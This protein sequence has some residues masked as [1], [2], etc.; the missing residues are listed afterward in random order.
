[1]H[2]ASLHTAL[3]Q[4]P[5]R[6][7]ELITMNPIVRRPDLILGLSSD[8]G[9]PLDSSD[10]TWV[11]TEKETVRPSFKRDCPTLCDHLG[12]QTVIFLF[13]PIAPVKLIGLAQMSHLA[14]PLVEFFV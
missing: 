13:A 10:V 11:G 1:M 4:S 2:R 14:Y 3:V 7:L 5:H 6:L 8:K 9:S 12:H